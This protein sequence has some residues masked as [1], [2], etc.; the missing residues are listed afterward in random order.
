MTILAA[1]GM[2]RIDNGALLAR[3]A[4]LEAELADAIAGRREET[5]HAWAAEREVERLRAELGGRG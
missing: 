1:N 3:I 4:Q 5:R 2:P